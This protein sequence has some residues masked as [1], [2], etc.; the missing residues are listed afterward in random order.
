MNSNFFSNLYTDEF[1]TQWGFHR[2][3][4]H[5]KQS[6]LLS[7]ILILV[8]LQFFTIHFRIYYS[9]IRISLFTFTYLLFVSLCTNAL[10][11]MHYALC[12]IYYLYVFIRIHYF[13]RIHTY[14]LFNV[15]KSL[16]FGTYV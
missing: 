12:I 2:V 3:Q 1:L 8:F 6:S 11:T 13:I 16:D 7:F 10:F 9:L 4:E 15:T 14:S 5:P